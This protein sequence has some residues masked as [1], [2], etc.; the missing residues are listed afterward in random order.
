[1]TSILLR[2]IGSLQCDQAVPLENGEAYWNLDPCGPDELYP[3]GDG[4]LGS[5]L[6]GVENMCDPDEVCELWYVFSCV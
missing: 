4:F 2:E 6:H 1:M 3:V 5:I